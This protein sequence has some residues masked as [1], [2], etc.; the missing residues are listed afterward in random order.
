MPQITGIGAIMI[1]AADPSALS[2]W[3][4]EFLGLSTTRDPNDGN[5]YGDVVDRDVDKTI[6]IGIYPA[7]RPLAQGARAVMINF[8]I[9]DLAALVERLMARGV[10]IESTVSDVHGR[11]V[12]IRDPEGNPLELWSEP[13]GRRD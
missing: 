1:Y 13:R 8:R 6:H 9:D 12:Y 11:F 2:R 4:A 10:A 7:E 3:Y 5:Y